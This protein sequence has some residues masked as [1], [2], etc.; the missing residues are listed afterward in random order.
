LPPLKD[1]TTLVEL[2]IDYLAD[3]H[4]L[5]GQRPGGYTPVVVRPR[6]SSKMC[7]CFVSLPHGFAGMIR[8]IGG[9]LVSGDDPAPPAS[10]I[11]VREW[12]P[13]LKIINPTH[14]VTRLV[15]TAN[16]V[17]ETPVKNCLTKDYTSVTI[18]VYLIFSIVDPLT[19]VTTLGPEKLD[20]LLSAAEEEAV[21]QLASTR[22][23][24]QM[25]DLFGTSA[26]GVVA[27]M[28]KN[29]QAYGVLIKQFTLK[30]VRVP[31][32]I[33][34]ILEMTTLTSSR[35]RRLE[36]ETKVEDQ[37]GEFE[38]EKVRLGEASENKKLSA[39]QTASFAKSAVQKEVLEVEALAEKSVSEREAET[40]AAVLELEAQAAVRVAKLEAETNK[41]DREISASTEAEVA[42]LKAQ[43]EAYKRKKHAE[44]MVAGMK[45]RADGMTKINYAEGEASQKLASRRQFEVAS[46][47]L[48]VI[49]SVAEN[50]MV[51]IASSDETALGLAPGNSTVARTAQAGMEAMQ[52]KFGE[53]AE[54][55]RAPVVQRM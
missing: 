10:D 29:F 17:F 14:A 15:S 16:F 26:E 48:D 25:F 39:E 12:T 51:R 38:E 55:S 22:T 35:E 45:L 33:V 41:I 49:E 2:E 5:I 43:A 8:S 32:Q 52:A 37:K 27:D 42:K 19:F 13:G 46:K 20:A 23:V 1:G 9:A 54:A 6:Q 34:E 50:P 47:R 3:A 53:I 21:R 24:T 44:A 7:C 28:N 36:V 31:N 30:Q 11:P 4:K 40:Q 18:D